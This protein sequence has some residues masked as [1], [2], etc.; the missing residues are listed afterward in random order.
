MTKT[1]AVNLSDAEIR[2]QAADASVTTLR[3]PRHPGLYFRFSAGRARGSWYLVVQRSWRRIAG[4][5]DLKTATVLAVLPELRQ[6]LVL[7][8]DA[9]A[10]NGAWRTVGHL[11]DWYGDRM[12]RDRSLSDK[13]KAGG[14]TAISCHLKPRLIDLPAAQLPR[15]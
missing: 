2:R 1:A 6:R 9:S 12:S 15:R 8:P 14:K 11:L 10:A 4:Y 3:D 7:N 5:P 13:R